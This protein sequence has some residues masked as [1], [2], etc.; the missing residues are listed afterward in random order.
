MNFEPQK[1]FI[2]LMDLFS[3]LLPGKSRGRLSGTDQGY[4]I[5]STFVE[6][7]RFIDLIDALGK[8]ARGLKTIMN[9]P[10]V[11]REFRLCQSLRVALHETET[12]RSKLAGILS[13]RDW[14][15]LL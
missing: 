10:K 7:K 11:E 12:L 3:I 1:F 14:D 4:E 9:Q 5:Q 13:A 8:V 6:L 15:A 2:S